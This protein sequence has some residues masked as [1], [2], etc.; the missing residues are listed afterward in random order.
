LI[1]LG[2][3]APGSWL[4][5]GGPNWVPRG[6]WRARPQIPGESVSGDQYHAWCWV[7]RT[8]RRSGRW[9]STRGSL[10]PEG[11]RPRPS[12]GRGAAGEPS[13]PVEFLCPAVSHGAVVGRHR[14][15]RLT[16]VSPTASGPTK[17]RVDELLAVGNVEAGCWSGASRR[18]AP[19][20][21]R[22]RVGACATVA[23][24]GLINS[25]PP[26]FPQLR[27]C[28]S[29]PVVRPP[30]RR[31]AHDGDLMGIA[32]PFRRDADSVVLAGGPPRLARPHSSLDNLTC[33]RPR[34]DRRPCGSPP[35]YGGAGGEPAAFD[36]FP[37]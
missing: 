25:P 35:A 11:G 32:R 9:E 37:R 13:A 23:N 29:R 28:G 18:K 12:S 24:R 5:L 20:T 15:R 7:H 34:N 8:A 19:A 14:G 22:H 30:A 21:R 1:P 2:K 3:W 26:P 10:A 17:K 36:R 6:P 33:A 4:K 27:R 31:H 16:R